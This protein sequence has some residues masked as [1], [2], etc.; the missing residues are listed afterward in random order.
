MKKNENNR[1]RKKRK[2]KRYLLKFLL[3]VALAVGLYYFLTSS[4]FDIQKISVEGNHYYTTEQVI[5]ISEAK[6]GVNLFEAS[7]S[8]M[9]DKLLANP[10][11][12]SAKVKRRLPNEIQLI[13]EER[14]ESAAVPYGDSFIILDEEGMILRNAQSELTLTII[15]GL[16]VTNMEEG[17]PLEAEENALM[18]E[19]LKL[20][21][22]TKDHELFFK[23][24][25][26]GNI[27]IKAYVYDQLICEGTPENLMNNMDS[28]QKVLY[29][30]YT[31]GI[32][33]GIIKMGKDG[34]YAFSP[35]IE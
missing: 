11:V 9:K 13:I 34:Y 10:Y 27:V 8:D 20:L 30:L 1:K 4:I 35:S 25:L 21:K 16:T 18:S 14:Q 6:T 31:K 2:K 28:L 29:D 7:A 33:R 22:E 15:E 3:L 23:K 24:I 26:L 32:E 12:K 17:T 5:A 19:T